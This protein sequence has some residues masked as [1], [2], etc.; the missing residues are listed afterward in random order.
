MMN[1]SASK[2]S[3]SIEEQSNSPRKRRILIVSGAVL[4]VAVFIC[5]AIVWSDWYFCLPEGEEANNEYVGRDKCLECHE[6]E[7]SLW[8][9]SDHDRSMDHATP[10]TVLGDFNEQ[11]FTHVG[12]DDI[13][14]LS[15]L[16]IRYL[17]DELEVGHLA[18]GL[19]DARHGVEDALRRNM[20]TEEIEIL[21]EELNVIEILRFARPCD[22]AASHHA[23]DQKLRVLADEGFVS[24]N[25]AQTSRMFTEDDAFF[26]ETDNSDGE[27]EIF[28]VKYVFGLRPLQQYL[29]EFDDGRVQCLPVA[30][31]TEN[32][33]WYHLYPK[34]QIPHDDPLHWTGSYQNWNY[35]CAECHSTNL[36]KN[37]DVES[38]E[39]DTTWA[40]I[41]VSCE[42]CHG[43]GGLHVRVAEAREDRILWNRWDRRYGMGLTV[44]VDTEN[45]TEEETDLKTKRIIESCAPCHSRRRVVQ[46]GPKP[47]HADFLDYYVPEM[48]DDDLYYSDGQILEEDYVYTSFLQ[49]RMYHEKVRCTDCHDA[50]SVRVKFNDNRL[51]T[52]CHVEA[53][54]DTQ[55]HHFHPDS[56]QPGTLCV[57]CHM[58]ETRYM[59]ADP[60]R[61]HSIRIP[62]PDLTL[63]LG[64]PNACNL[65]H[66]DVR[67]GETPE[68]AAQQCEEWYPDSETTDQYSFGPVALAIDA[69][70]HR[71]PAAVDLL[72][73]VTRMTGEEA[74]PL[75]RASAVALLDPLQSGGEATQ[76][77]ALESEHGLLRIAAITA[78]QEPLQMEVDSYWSMHQQAVAEMRRAQNV[79][80]PNPPIG[81]PRIS[82]LMERLG[83]LL[84]D[85]LQGVRTEAARVLCIVPPRLRMGEDNE[86]IDSFHTAFKEYVESQYAAADQSS[87]HMNLGIVHRAM[88]DP[89]IRTA[90]DRLA[91]MSQIS[92]PEASERLQQEYAAAVQSAT[93]SAYDEYHIGI[94][95]DPDQVNIRFNLAMLC[96][97]RNEKEEA[98]RHLR[99]VIRIDAGIVDAHY[100]L[101]LLIAEDMERM[102]DAEACFAE[103]AR[104]LPEALA[105]AHTSP[106]TEGA[107]HSPGLTHGPTLFDFS[108]APRIYYNYGLS[109]QHQER[110]EDAEGPLLQALELQPGSTE[111]VQTLGILYS[112]W[113]RPD[114]GLAMTSDQLRQSAPQPM[115]INLHLTFL[116]QLDR[117]DDAES[118]LERLETAEPRNPEWP[119]ALQELQRLRAEQ[120]DSEEA[121][122][123]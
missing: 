119:R 28:P 27:L 23:V 44:F 34:E 81:N 11:S 65:C 72:Y 57:E 63:E 4:L 67:N 74:R 7:H 16:E 12:F 94:R 76:F 60:R 111:F 113:E 89:T 91:V 104:M 87:A 13:L 86:F 80:F 6:Q 78:L 26:I 22:I 96:N 117:W 106:D 97:D 64:T 37:F 3:P 62:R 48:I 110:W 1:S 121:S 114:R 56:T 107:V 5:G 120:E 31:D 109:L 83:P 47:P 8:H 85:P 118:F 14:K 54:Y 53:N 92:P 2:M 55:Q 33:R 93:Q 10:E 36:K 122:T 90:R 17:L 51:C 24:L 100:A 35:M 102:P 29:V 95:L 43:Q 19:Q 21:D 88:A 39:Y 99:E 73:D 75:I 98:E 84:E 69:G 101:G 77:E 68:W 52:Q 59:G 112:Q 42:T 38:N 79:L 41:N 58:P 108:D 71:D 105:S 82:R 32:R 123:E 20:T 15:D 61:D 70:K 45:D 50:H 49:S 30:W 116:I 9:G 40:E 25:F 46:E 115:L 18:Y 66:N 103:A